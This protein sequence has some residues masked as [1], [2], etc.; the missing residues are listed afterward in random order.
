MTND[1][2]AQ[3]DFFSLKI[4]DPILRKM[5]CFTAALCVV[6]CPLAAFA[7]D[8][9]ILKPDVPKLDLAPTVHSMPKGATLKGNIE[10]HTKLH[11]PPQNKPKRLNSR[12]VKPDLGPLNGML[13][14]STDNGK[15]V[16]LGAD[17]QQ[18]YVLDKSIGIIGIKFLKMG[19][20]PAMV[21]RVFPGTPAYKVGFS[22][23]DAIVAVDGV[24]IS[25]LNKDECYD[26]IVGTPNTPISVTLMHHGN[27]EVKN[28]M[29][30][31]F[32]EIPD[33]MVRR[34]YLH[35]L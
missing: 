4:G 35:S 9:A 7:E 23:D 28:M 1:R 15:S 19:E 22:V 16:T 33:P 20:R 24:P 6:S 3:I 13:N 31:D 12:I 21:N 30:M 25:G 14:G 34:D 29:R 18:Q 11:P 27:F 26:L 2:R 32:N 17:A 10:H 5:F 8:E